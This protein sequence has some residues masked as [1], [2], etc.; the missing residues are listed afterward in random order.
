MD[1]DIWLFTY[2]Y[3]FPTYKLR[4]SLHKSPY[5][6]PTFQ[7]SKTFLIVVVML[8]FC[9]C[10]S[11]DRNSSSVQKRSTDHVLEQHQVQPDVQM[12]LGW[13]NP[14]L[15]YGTDFLNAISA[16]KRNNPAN[17]KVLLKFTASRSI[18]ELG[19]KKVLQWY[20]EHNLNMQKKLVSVQKDGAEFVCSYTTVINA[21]ITQFV[22]H[23]SLEND[24]LRLL[25][26]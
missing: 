8:N 20:R 15:C 13:R 23:L 6:K 10:S 18:K 19:E 12:N 16:M 3:A 5:I 25:I 11:D 7:I 21:T 24:T 17:E 2:Q 26:R 4:I 9:G 1:T 14:A 22:I